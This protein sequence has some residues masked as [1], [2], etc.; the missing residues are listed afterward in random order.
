M[1]DR[2]IDIRKCIGCGK[3]EGDCVSQYIVMKELEHGK[4][5]AS[6]RERGYCIE[7]GHC[8]AIC[9]Q[10]AILG[11][12]IDTSI[13]NE[14]KLLLLM[15]QKRTVREYIKDS[16]ISQDVLKKIL[17]A[18]ETAPTAHNR[19]SARIILIKEKLKQLYLQALDYLVL[20]VQET[21]TINSMYSS[22]M[23]MNEKRDE[24]LW[25]AEYLVVFAGTKQSLIDSAISAERM[26]LE[27][28]NLNIGTAYRGDIQRAIN[29]DDGLRNLLGLKKNEEVLISF[30]MGM[31]SKKYLRPAIKSN[32]KIVFL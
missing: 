6:F 12:R 26:Q 17:L 19:K 8:N 11:G 9:P 4:K 13:E 18:G 15:G 1:S 22:I 24:I 2:I 27:A 16:K 3:C 10:N 23:H 25:N 14:D 32:H 30:A 28:Y 29:N 31:T 20:E 7:C 21:G 5:I